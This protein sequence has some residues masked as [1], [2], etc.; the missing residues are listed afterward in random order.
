MTKLPLR[1]RRHKAVLDQIAR[2]TLARN[3]AIKILVKAE[4]VLPK[5]E[6]QA[7]RFELPVK[8]RKP[9]PMVEPE[10]VAP[11]KRKA[12]PVDPTTQLGVLGPAPGFNAKGDRVPDD[13]ASRMEDAGF[14]K[15]KSGKRKSSFI[16][17]ELGKLIG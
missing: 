9:K 13:Y 1:E 17:R 10:P 15:L 6:R 7:R 12:K 14:R 11:T 16:E 5:L 4:T 3:K 8:P 2:L